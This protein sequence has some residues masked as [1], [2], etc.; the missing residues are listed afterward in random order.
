MGID[1]EARRTRVSSSGE[2]FVRVVFL[3]AP[4]VTAACGST[5]PPAKVEPK[6]ATAGGVLE[7]LPLE[8]ETVYSYE[9]RVEPSGE[10]GLLI[11]EI[12]RRR[13]ELAELVVAGRAQRLNVSPAAIE[14][15]TGGALLR[16]PLEEGATWRG[17][18]GRVRVTSISRTVTVPAG[19]FRKCLETVEEMTNAEGTKRTTTTYC[20]AV[21]ITLRE[22]E[23]EQDAQ[24]AIERIELKSFGKRFSVES[25]SE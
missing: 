7:Y 10:R 24:H 4:L 17:D 2:A 23:V 1:P 6:P 3:A 22:T 11:L 19:T 5:P 12:R 18:F 21:G 13:P 20:P 15:V 9:T 14:L 8:H 25:Q 16:A